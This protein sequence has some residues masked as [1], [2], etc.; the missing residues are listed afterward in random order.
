METDS[1]IG[2]ACTLTQ[3]WEACELAMDVH[4]RQQ[5]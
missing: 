3:Y 4:H 5:T 2:D 1:R